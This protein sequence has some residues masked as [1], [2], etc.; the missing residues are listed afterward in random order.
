MT[1]PRLD[2]R[3][4]DPEGDQACH[5]GPEGA[6]AHDDST[7]AQASSSESA[8][9]GLEGY[10]KKTYTDAEWKQWRK[11]AGKNRSKP[12]ARTAPSPGEFGGRAWQKH[13][14]E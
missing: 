14:E 13:E 5:G 1:S 4:G 2:S 12:V 8:Q 10:A 6:G 7:I 3:Q 9:D 11:Q